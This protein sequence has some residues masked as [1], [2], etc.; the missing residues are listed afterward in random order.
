MLPLVYSP[1]PSRVPFPQQL[2]DLFG[3]YSFRF[4]NH[5]YAPFSG[6]WLKTYL[7]AFR[8]L[9]SWGGAFALI[10]TRSDIDRQNQ[11]IKESEKMKKRNAGVSNI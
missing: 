1:W 3:H 2:H 9:Y 8:V 11:S 5:L 6:W 7:I 10:T 4:S